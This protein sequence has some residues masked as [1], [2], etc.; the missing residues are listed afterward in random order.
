MLTISESTHKIVTLSFHSMKRFSA[1]VVLLL[2]SLNFFGFYAYYAFR[3]V[4][5]RREMRMQL[6]FL[7]EEQLNRFVF[8]TTEYNEVMRGDDEVQVS[9]CMYDIARM[10]MYKDSVLILALHDEAEDNLIAFIQTIV[11]R[12]ATDKKPLPTTVM[13]FFTLV[14]LLPAFEWEGAA[15]VRE[16]GH[17]QHLLAYSSFYP[18]QHSPPP[19]V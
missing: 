14:Y 17:T 16:T 15:Q 9:G 3:L 12:S 8:S 6:Q 13:V 4:E 2:F 11:E 5:I 10:E 1:F 7:P 18:G 19:R